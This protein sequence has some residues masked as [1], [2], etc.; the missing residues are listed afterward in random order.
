M[1][2]SLVSGRIVSIKGFS[3]IELMVVL[4]IAVVLMGVAVPSFQTLLQNQ[5]MTT[6]VN[7]FF[8]AIILA[9]AKAIDRGGRVDMGPLDGLDW[10]N[11]WVV[12]INTKNDTDMKY[13]ADDE[14]IFKHEAVHTGITI[15]S[16]FTDN[17]TKYIAYNGTGYTRTNSGTQQ[18]QAGNVTITQGTVVKCITLN[19]LG[20]P[21][22]YTPA[23]GVTNCT[24]TY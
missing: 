18:F 24:S 13:E 2:T 4:T 22:V 17:A 21:R 7:E 8:A 3:L 14:L 6:T 12:F 5:R 11:G 9:R 1:K 15:A 20:R 23:T 19:F 16:N 10:N